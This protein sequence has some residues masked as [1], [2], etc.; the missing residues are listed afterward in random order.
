M[1][2]SDFDY[3]LPDELIAQYPP[4]ERGSSRLLV[5][6]SNKSLP[7]DR[8]FS[9]LPDLLS[10]G[11]LLI[12]NDTR[13]MKARLHGK[14]ETGGR[15][16]VLIE[17]VSEPGLA[18]AQVRASKSPKINSKIL[19]GEAGDRVDV[20]GREG[21]FFQLRA[22]DRDFHALMDQQGHMPLP[23]YIT[24][25]DEGVDESRYQ[26][27]YAEKMGAVAAP[28]AGL[29]FSNEMLAELTAKG[30][31]QARVTLHVG[32]GTFQPVR[33]DDLDQH[34]MHREY[35]EVDQAVCDLIA[36]TK[37]RKG[38]VIAVGTTSVRSLESAAQTGV[39]QPLRG[40][41]RLFIRPG[42]QFNV[43]D[44]MITNFH[45]PQST[46]M[47]LVSAFAGYER[48]MGAY[49]HAVEQRYRFF[50]YG[51]AMFLTPGESSGA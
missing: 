40:D 21:E 48:L 32:A 17:R 44:A 31:N 3:F 35:A 15:V 12:F 49:R 51:D 16:E 20:I 24:R 9:G 4:E 50:S 5:L 42:F 41:T 22:V 7:E 36:E 27:V 8:Q 2:L 19:L 14:K 46:L 28:T 37:Q 13:V 26:T 25:R 34:V 43:V 1:R 47:M 23:P 11:D 39:L 6:P 45:L 33:V 29:H 10:A 38:R 18:L 30:V